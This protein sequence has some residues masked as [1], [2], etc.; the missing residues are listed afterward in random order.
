M[1]PGALQIRV[2]E[3]TITT[4]PISLSLKWMCFTITPSDILSSWN[5][6]LVLSPKNINF[7]CRSRGRWRCG[8]SFESCIPKRC[9]L[10]ERWGSFGISFWRFCSLSMFPLPIIS[11]AALL[12]ASSGVKSSVRHRPL[13]TYL[14]DSLTRFKWSATLCTRLARS[15]LYTTNLLIFTTP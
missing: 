2:E 13:T 7:G 3:Q 11:R 10:L 8:T 5:C 6:C 15:I 1:F 12:P 14:V 9:S 4:I